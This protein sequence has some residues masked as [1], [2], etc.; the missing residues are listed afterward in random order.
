MFTH[1]DRI[2]AASVILAVGLVLIALSAYY[3]ILLTRPCPHNMFS[4]GVKCLPIAVCSQDEVLVDNY[5]TPKWYSPSY[6]LPNYW[7]TI[8]PVDGKLISSDLDKDYDNLLYTSFFLYQLTGLITSLKITVQEACVVYYD[9]DCLGVYIGA[10]DQVVTI[11]P[12]YLK[13]GYH[14]LGIQYVKNAHDG[15]FVPTYQR[16][17]TSTPQELTVMTMVSTVKGVTTRGVWFTTGPVKEARDYPF[18]GI[19]PGKILKC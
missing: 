3:L 8:V 4:N 14:V 2:V 17:S 9:G 5:C 1:Q 11:P 13:A 7:K 10:K 16:I 18:G 12:A 19:L 6:L 15:A